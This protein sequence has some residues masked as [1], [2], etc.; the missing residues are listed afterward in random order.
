MFFGLGTLADPSLSPA[1]RGP[2]CPPAVACDYL[3]GP[4]GI[5]FGDYEAW[6]QKKLGGLRVD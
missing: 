1:V 2:G 4:L 3:Y 5:S 6:N